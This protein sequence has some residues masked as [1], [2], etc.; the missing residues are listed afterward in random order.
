MRVAAIAAG[1]VLAL[2]LTSCSSPAPTP[3]APTASSTPAPSVEPVVA[4][5]TPSAPVV[6][7]DELV[8]RPS[9]LELRRDG[10]IITTLDYMSPAA[11]AVAA[12]T[13]AFGYAP[14]DE[15][16]EGTNHRP[17]GVYHAWGPVVVDER[18]YDE[19]RRETDG[20]FSLDW[21]RFAVYFDAPSAGDVVLR[22]AGDHRQG[23]AWSSVLDDPESDIWACE[24]TPVESEE[25]YTSRGPGTVTVV[26]RENDAG[27]A[28]LWLGAPAMEAGGCA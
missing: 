11:D 14:A 9:A 27:D 19:E 10:Q 7:V 23:E 1:T 25:T 8:M 17:P 5:P 6:T 21:P 24:G 20:L 4:T 15:P 26:A 2:L 3:D 13:E 18:Y 28:V 12:L 16:Y 22:T